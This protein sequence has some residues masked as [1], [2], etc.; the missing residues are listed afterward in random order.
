M[1]TTAAGPDTKA[2]FTLHHLSRSKSTELDQNLESGK[3]E[4]LSG[5]PKKD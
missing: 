2:P 1:E 5:W 4:H 3:S